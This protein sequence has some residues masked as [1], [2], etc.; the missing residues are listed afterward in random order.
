MIADPAK[1][2]M[3]WV[4]VTWELIV[5]DTSPFGDS[6]FKSSPFETS[7]L[8]SSL[9]EYSSVDVFCKLHWLVSVDSSYPESH[10]SH[11][12]VVLDVHE[13][14][15]A[16]CHDNTV[17]LTGFWY[18]SDVSTMV[19]SIEN[20]YVVSVDTFGVVNVNLLFDDSRV[21]QSG[22]VLPLYDA[23]EYCNVWVPVEIIQLSSTSIS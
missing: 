10:V 7:S 8:E 2:T 21:T 22:T 5:S 11:K 18:V 20:V 3:D 16:T 4:L 1:P 23:N 17:K 12:L 6:V 9:F 19:E 13:A 15:F 14:Q